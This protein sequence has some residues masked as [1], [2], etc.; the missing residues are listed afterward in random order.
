MELVREYPGSLTPELC[1]KIIKLFEEDERKHIGTMSRGT[2][3][4]IKVTTDLEVFKTDQKWKE[5]DNILTSELNTKVVEYI[6][7]LQLLN[8]LK[9]VHQIEDSGYKIQKYEKNKGF[10]KYH[11]DAS[12]NYKKNAYRIITF[13]WYLNTV[14][15]G[16]ETEFLNKYKIKPEAGKLLLFPATWTYPHTGVMPISSDK[17]IATGWMY[18]N[19]PG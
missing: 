13:L 19:Y 14:D 2:D 5:I 8:Y 9:Y 12:I 18:I 10:Y 6:K 16:G 1:N 4:S 17:Y 15:E 3:L 7:E 11:D